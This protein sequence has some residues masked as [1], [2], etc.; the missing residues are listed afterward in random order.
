MENQ[1][2]QEVVLP[3]GPRRVDHNIVG[4]LAPA[5]VAAQILDGL[6]VASRRDRTKGALVPINQHTSRNRGVEFIVGKQNHEGVS[7]FFKTRRNPQ[8]VSLRGV[9]HHG[10]VFGLYL[11]PDVLGVSMGKKEKSGQ[12]RQKYD[13]GTGQESAE[14]F[15]PLP[16]ES[17]VLGGAEQENEIGC[18]RFSDPRSVPVVYSL[19][20]DFSKWFVREKFNRSESIRL[21]HPTR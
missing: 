8:E 11:P 10:E 15:W 17:A 1:A 7:E 5:E 3:G 12:K 14:H 19:A 21:R 13:S 20:G 4:R 16:Q 6:A 2:V 9:S 18:F